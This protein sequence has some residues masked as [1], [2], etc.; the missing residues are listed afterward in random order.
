ML[1]L[2]FGMFYASVNVG[3]MLCMYFIPMVRSKW[4][5]VQTVWFSSWDTIRYYTVQQ[6]KIQYNMIQ[7]SIIQYNMEH[8]TIRKN[9][10]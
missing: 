8:N 2:F 3:A 9:V 5:G 10:I 4:G 7:Y 6:N 1:E